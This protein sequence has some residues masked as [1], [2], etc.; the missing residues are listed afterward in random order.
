MNLKLQSEEI[1]FHHYINKISSGVPLANNKIIEII[2]SA[3]AYIKSTK[4]LIKVF[5]KVG[6]HFEY[7]K[8]ELGEIV[9]ILTVIE[10]KERNG[11][12]TIDFLRNISINYTALPA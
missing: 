10:D 1:N 8:T 2:E 7:T 3:I 11:L 9:S 4:E 12:Q 6:F 5:E